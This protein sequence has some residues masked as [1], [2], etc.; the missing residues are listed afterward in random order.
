MIGT[1]IFVSNKL[2]KGLEAVSFG[3]I[4]SSINQGQCCAIKSE[5]KD[6]QNLIENESYIMNY[7]NGLGLPEVK[8][9]A[10]SSRLY[11]SYEI[12]G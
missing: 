5:E 9:F 10:Y 3:S 4:H 12:N 7:L 11:S 8:Y 6:N 2:F 1:L